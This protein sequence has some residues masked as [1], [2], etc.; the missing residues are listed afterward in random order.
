MGIV[1]KLVGLNVK[2][3]EADRNQ[4]KEGGLS[5]MTESDGEGMGKNKN[6]KIILMERNPYL[7][8]K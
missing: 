2:G 1:V 6:G 3:L 8:L 5:E 7:V 4:P